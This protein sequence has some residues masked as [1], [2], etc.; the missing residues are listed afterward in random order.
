MTSLVPVGPEG[1]VNA[2]RKSG[3]WQG[4]AEWLALALNGLDSA[5]RSG[6]IDRGSR[7]GLLDDH[8]AVAHGERRDI[9]VIVLPDGTRVCWHAAHTIRLTRWI[10]EH[11]DQTCGYGR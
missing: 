2:S 6:A 8:V 9:D 4:V 10:V 11:R 3:S 1:L 7:A 5:V